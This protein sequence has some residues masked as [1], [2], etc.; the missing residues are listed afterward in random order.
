MQFKKC[1]SL[2]LAIL[3]LVSNLGLAFN[4]HYCGDKIASFSSAFS[5]IQNQKSQDSFKSDCCCVKQDQREDSC[6]K[7][8]VIDLKKESKDVLIKTLLF[9]ID[10]P[11]VLIKS[12]EFLFAKTE[13]ITSKNNITAYYCSPNA[14]PLFKLY[15]Q[16]IF[17]A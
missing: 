2:F 17:Y 9:Q 14:P 4:V 7:D 13:K 3:L 5:T 11:F 6:C 15:K 8:K 10:A 12:S 16:Y 1:T